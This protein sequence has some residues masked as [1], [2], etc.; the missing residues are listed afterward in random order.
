MTAIVHPPRTDVAAR[1]SG[2]ARLLLRFGVGMVDLACR[3]LLEALH[4]VESLA[5]GELEL[6]SSEPIAGGSEP[7]RGFRG[8]VDQA[9]VREE[10]RE[11]EACAPPADAEPPGAVRDVFVGAL[12]SLPEALTAALASAA[13]ARARMG[14]IARGGGRLLEAV[15]GARTVV[16]RCRAASAGAA[17]RLTRL[18]AVGRAEAEAGRRLAQVFL[19]SAS[20]A[21]VARV[22]ESPELKRVIGEQS[23]GLATTAVK[24]LRERSARADSA[25][26]SVLRRLTGR[27]RSGGSK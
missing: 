13:P 5:S 7:V 8:G 18:S 19:S 24:E 12:A 6:C 25:A 15:P 26:E 22:A 10:Q 1:G 9:A 23:Q 27:S 20:A 17:G 21:A 4:A 2:S 14:R 16:R 3:R 11:E